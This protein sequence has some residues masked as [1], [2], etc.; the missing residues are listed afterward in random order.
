MWYESAMIYRS[1]ALENTEWTVKGPLN[2]YKHPLPKWYRNNN[3]WLNTHWQCHDIFNETG[4]DPAFVLS[5]TVEIAQRLNQ[6]TLALHWYEWQQ[7]DKFS[8]IKIVC[9]SF[10]VDTYRPRSCSRV[11]IFV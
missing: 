2:T 6:S 9:K 4:G 8:L 10:N 3:I 7:G 5:N 1:W 11:S